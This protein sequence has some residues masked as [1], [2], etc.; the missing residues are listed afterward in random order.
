[1]S[2]IGRCGWKSFRWEIALDSADP[3]AL[4]YAHYES[5][6]SWGAQTDAKDRSDIFRR[7]VSRAGVVAPARILE[8]GFGGGQF[9]DWA[10]ENGFEVCG[11][12]Q[13]EDQCAKAKSRGH[14]VYC[15]NAATVLERITG[16]F[17]LIVL[18][19]VCEHLT[20]P[21]L[22]DLFAS[23]RARL[24]P[25]GVVFTRFPNGGSPFGGVAQ[26]GDA[27]HVTTLTG[28]KIDQISQVS[29][30]RLRAQYEAYASELTEK[31]KGFSGHRIPKI[32]AHKLQKLVNVSISLLYFGKVIPM[33]PV[34]VALLALDG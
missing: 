5:W 21:E 20:V 3:R 7:E 4:F 19:D 16:S 23:A 33:S 26:H 11:I 32:I 34:M 8:I 10:Q 17:D 6:K 9:L 22:V 29:S 15:G 24:A 30:L 18:F 1:M 28:S 27:T 14:Q 13:L 2:R 31:G 12:E 25:K